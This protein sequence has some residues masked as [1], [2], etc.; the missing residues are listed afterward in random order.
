MTDIIVPNA[1]PI[2]VAILNWF[3]LGAVGYLTISQHQ[4]AVAAAL[5]TIVLAAVGVGFLIPI[6]AAI[7]GYQVASKLASGETLKS[8]YCDIA[9]LSKLPLWKEL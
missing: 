6:I 5:Y 4:K 3:F 9:F 2:A 1:N 7:D 8:D